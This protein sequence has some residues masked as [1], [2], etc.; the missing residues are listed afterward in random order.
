MIIISNPLTSKNAYHDHSLF[1]IWLDLFDRRM[2][3]VQCSTCCKRTVCATHPLG[4]STKSRK[5]LSLNI[6]VNA[7]KGF[8]PFHHFWGAFIRCSTRTALQPGCMYRSDSWESL[9]KSY[10][11]WQL[12]TDQNTFFCRWFACV[13]WS[14]RQISQAWLD[15]SLNNYRRRLLANV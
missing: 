14:V 5:S 3:V 11:N 9:G 10:A 8:K 2:R 7:Q 4:S 12:F 15:D 1:E 6:K 13:N